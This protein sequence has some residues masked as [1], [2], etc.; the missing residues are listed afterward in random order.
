L[1]WVWIDN[2]RRLAHVPPEGIR[3]AVVNQLSSELVTGLLGE[4]FELPR[5]MTKDPHC[6]VVVCTRDR[7]E[8]L[9]D[10]LISLNEL[11]YPSFEILVVDNAPTS[12][13]TRA[14]LAGRPAR[15]TR[16]D[17]PGLDWARNR[18]LLEASG[19]IVAFVDDDARPDRGWLR[20]IANAFADPEV[21]AVSGMVAPVELET[22][23]QILFE[24]PLGGMT[25]SVRRWT[26]R[27]EGTSCTQLLW[28][29][30]YAV[31]TN[32]AFRRTVFESEATFDP[33]L[34]VGTA[35]GS[36][37]D[38]EMCHRLVAH[39]HTLVYEPAALVW[40]VHRRTQTGL[41]RQLHANGL[42]FGAYLMT[43]A[44]NRTVSRW[45]I[46]RF[47]LREWLWG[48][49]VRRLV[50]PGDVPRR[51]VWAELLGALRSPLAYRAARKQ[52]RRLAATVP[53]AGAS[54]RTAARQR[55]AQLETR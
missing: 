8:L 45:S 44:R 42:G 9:A 54:E 36:G 28:S 34:D 23:A 19:E 55:A 14:L 51:L 53:S 52:A 31:G 22:L 40:H 4:A 12:D 43:C 41:R 20:A 27:R 48:W 15:Y 26:V 38:L 32:M 37:G 30:S 6:T 17:R 24:L 33:A 29:S 47:A 35:S 5:P 49:I 10:C 1:G 50:R 46:L 21:M 16:E 25:Q 2:T 13:A 11:D 3:D 39:G 7:A 18:G